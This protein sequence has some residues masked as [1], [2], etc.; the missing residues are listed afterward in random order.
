MSSCATLFATMRCFLSFLPCVLLFSSSLGFAATRGETCT[1]EVVVNAFDSATKADLYGLRAEDFE[2]RSAGQDSS[3][4]KAAPVLHNRVL[5]LA[6]ARGAKSLSQARAIAEMVRE[7]VPPQM[8]VAFGVIAGQAAATPRFYS[9][10]DLFGA[11]IA[12]V[13]SRSHAGSGAEAPLDAALRQALHLFG[14]ARS[15]DT[16]LL[17]TSGTHQEHINVRKLAREFNQHQVRLQ[18]LMPP[19]SVSSGG[20][21]AVFSS[22]DAADQFSSNLLELAAKTGGALM[23]FM[24]SDWLDA[25]SSGYTLSIDLPPNGGKGKL[26]K[27]YL[28]EKEGNAELFY[29]EEVAGCTPS[30]SASAARETKPLP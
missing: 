22:W 27:L 5:V 30:Y 15:G 18:L 25:A 11:A 8:P 7:Q 14:P 23:G 3:V 6:D 24:N 20:P 19:E 4:L 9:D 2:A 17:I 13:F 1:T 28:R 26:M 29:P 10:Y 12:K 16:V 21:L